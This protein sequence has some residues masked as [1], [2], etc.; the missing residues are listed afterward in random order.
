MWDVEAYSLGCVEVLAGV[1]SFRFGMLVWCLNP[2]TQADRF[3]ELQQEQRELA[4][5]GLVT[6]SSLVG[7]LPWRVSLC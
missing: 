6:V 4:K 2:S 1:G 5:M 3:V 7:F